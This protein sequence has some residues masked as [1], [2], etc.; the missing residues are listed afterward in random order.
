MYQYIMILC[1]YTPQLNTY[2]YL[3]SVQTL[4]LKYIKL[5]PFH[6]LKLEILNNFPQNKLCLGHMACNT[7]TTYLN[8]K[9]I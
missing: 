6:Q 5:G 8:N 2:H 4:T 9:H 3:I 7:N 1:E